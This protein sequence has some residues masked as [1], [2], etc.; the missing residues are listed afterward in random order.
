MAHILA[1][2]PVIAGLG[3]QLNN[4]LTGGGIGTYVK[5]LF[6]LGGIALLIFAVVLV[7]KHAFSSPPSLGR[8]IKEGLVA[9]LVAVVLL[10]PAVRG[11]ILNGGEAGVNKLIDTFKS[12]G[13]NNGALPAPNQPPSQKPGT[14]T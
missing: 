14:S 10:V 1:P 12:S 6:F 11:N 9:L 7:A 8:G 4:F 2:P 13:N 5:D 3:D